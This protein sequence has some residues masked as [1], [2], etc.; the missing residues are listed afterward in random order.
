MKRIAVVCFVVV[1]GV[2]LAS[3]EI[4][5]DKLNSPGPSNVGGVPDA[6][7]GPDDYGY[8]YADNA[9]AA[10]AGLYTFVD[11][12]TTGTAAGLF[13]ADDE[14][15]GPF[16]IGFSFD[17]YGTAQTQFYV[18]TNG[19]VYFEDAYLGLG[20]TCPLPATQSYTPQVFIAPY[21]DDLVVQSDGE[22]YYETFASCPVGNGAQCTIVQFY[23]MRPYSGVEGDNMNFE[24]VLYDD[25][26]VALLYAQPSGSD[27]SQNNGGSATVGIQGSP[28]PSPVYALEYSC[29]SASLS[30]GLAIAFAHPSAI[31]GGI[32]NVCEQPA[33]PTPAG[34]QPIPTTSN[35]GLIVLVLLLVVAAFVLISRRAV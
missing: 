21:H 14:Y 5:D 1:F 16:A 12:T 22:I 18:G 23:N 27:P 6:A 19:T 26:S 20:N 3:A 33:T 13:G 24:V 2:G 34:P 30:S 7:G 9:E 31:T 32:P 8:I 15:A 10:C 11:I 17:F 25:G 4:A 35:T 28:N 29:N